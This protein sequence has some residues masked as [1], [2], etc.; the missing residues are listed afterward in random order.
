MNG[1][2]VAAIAF[3]LIAVGA[4]AWALKERLRAAEAGLR[5]STDVGK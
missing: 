2:L 5:G 1:S 3:G 4:I